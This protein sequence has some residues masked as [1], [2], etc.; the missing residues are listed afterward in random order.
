MKVRPK[1]GIACAFAALLAIGIVLFSRRDN[2]AKRAA[3]ETHQQLR[4]ENLKTR[5]SEF[6]FH[7]SP[8]N[9]A[10]AHIITNTLF[11][12]SSPSPTMMEIRNAD[13]ANSAM[14]AAA[15][16]TSLNSFDFLPAAGAEWDAGVP[17]WKQAELRSPD[18]ED[19][20]PDLGRALNS[21]RASLDAAVAA[22]LDGPIR[23]D[24]DA[25]RGASLLLPHLSAMRNLSQTLGSRVVFELHQNNRAAAWTNLLATTRLATAWEPEPVEI[26]HQVRFAQLRTAF[27]VTWQWLQAGGWSDAQLAQL[28]NE[29]AQVDL[30]KIPVESIA[31]TRATMVG[32]LQ[33]YRVEPYEY[34]MS[35]MQMIRSPRVGWS[36]IEAARTNAR[37][38]AVG[39][40]EDEK[41]L[42]LFFR[43][44]EIEMREAVRAATWREMQKHS[45]TT[46]LLTFQ[47]NRGSPVTAM[48]NLRALSGRQATG[49]ATF[50]SRVAETE[51][52]RRLI[53]AALGVERFRIKHGKLPKTIAEVAEFAPT[54]ALVDFMDGQSLRYRVAGENG[55]VLYSVGLDLQDDGGKAANPDSSWM[56]LAPPRAG[57]ANP[58]RIIGSRP[59]PLNFY[60]FPDLVWPRPATQEDMKANTAQRRNSMRLPAPPR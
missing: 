57:P 11:N 45:I 49:G 47:S 18:G 55:F 26:S 4:S 53:L 31:Y 34:S 42:L 41:E 10:R 48:M 36:E 17:I 38:R 13:D 14:R 59:T 50:L 46:N 28:Q 52:R 54:K 35:P 44:R 21:N 60:P 19:L 22:I 56:R 1:L 6:N 20:W 27:N 25:N 5:L 16:S 15:R 7:T 33:A 12:F 32:A 39:S 3:E 43:E 9:R 40:Y 24:L 8:E 37:F 2:A 58:A 23:I 29:W 30:L 51:E